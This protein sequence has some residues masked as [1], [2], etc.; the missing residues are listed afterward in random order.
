M[1]VVGIGLNKTGTKTLRYCLQHW[2]FRHK[3]FDYE[4]FQQYLRGDVAGLLDTMA[5]YDSFEDWPWPLIY[6]EID[7]RFPDARFVLTRRTNPDVWYRSLCNMAVRMGPLRRYEQHVYGYAM[8]QGHR[9]EHIRFY[10]A[11][12]ESVRAHFRD[13]PGKLLE[14]CWEDGDDWQTLAGFLNLD[15]PEAP[16][17]HVNRSPRVYSGDNLLLA[18]VNR[19]VYQSTSGVRR[20]MR[21]IV[22]G[23][24]RRLPF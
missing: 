17:R 21:R 24:R 7:A 13:R 5:A 3:T 19:V 22:G 12:N 15:V 6:R 4:A 10:E 11:H 16:L 23:I 20:Q 14:V 18:H 9:D 8:P 2:G 1:K